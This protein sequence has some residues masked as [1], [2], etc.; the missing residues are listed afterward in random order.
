MLI[1]LPRRLVCV[2]EGQVDEAAAVLAATL[3]CF[4][5]PVGHVRLYIALDIQIQIVD[6]PSA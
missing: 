5:P 1:D 2:L 6:L 4:T 3:L